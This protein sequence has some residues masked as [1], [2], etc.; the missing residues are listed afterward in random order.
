M[1]HEAPAAWDVL[2]V[3]AVNTPGTIPMKTGMTLREAIARAGGLS[4]SGTDKGIQVT[5]GGG[6]AVKMDSTA[7]VQANDVIVVRERLF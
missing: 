1:K 3:D 4:E 2:L 7:K 5:R 6:K